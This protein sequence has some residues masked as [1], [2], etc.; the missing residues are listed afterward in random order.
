MKFKRARNVILVTVFSLLFNSLFISN[1]YAQVFL[2]K[3]EALNRAFPEA[4]KIVSKSVIITKAKLA[5]IEQLAQAPVKS[6][7]YTFFVG[8][9]QDQVLGYASI[10]SAV[11]HSM[12]A[13]FMI[14]LSPTGEVKDVVVLAFH[15]SM[16]YLPS[17]AWLKQFHG[18]QRPKDVKLGENIVSM[19]GATLSSRTIE[20]GVRKA[21]AVLDVMILKK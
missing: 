11:V 2:A 17:N 5:K 9:K 8:M 4:S 6:K 7:L 21:M 13:T 14:H 20:R 16:N 19:A 15:E 1:L 10:E 3:D 12:P 18:I